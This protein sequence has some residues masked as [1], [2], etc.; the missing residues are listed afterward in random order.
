MLR[1]IGTKAGGVAPAEAASQVLAALRVSAA[2]AVLPT[3]LGGVVS[4]VEQTAGAVSDRLKGLF[5]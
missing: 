5:K 2:Q 1:E 3:Q 4:R